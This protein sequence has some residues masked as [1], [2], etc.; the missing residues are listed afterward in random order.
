MAR[1]KLSPEQVEVLQA[2][3]R[4]SEAA[5]QREDRENALSALVTGLEQ[6]YP[7]QVG[8]PRP[9]RDLRSALAPHIVEGRAYWD[10]RSQVDFEFNTAWAWTWDAVSKAA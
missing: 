8:V 2:A 9:L 3:L 10:V 7:N 1:R 6:V 5:H 4:R